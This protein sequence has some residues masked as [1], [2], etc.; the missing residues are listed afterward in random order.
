MREVLHGKRFEKNLKLVKKRGKDLNKIFKLIEILQKDE[1]I[2]ARYKN[3][4]LIGN[5]DGYWELHIEPDWL[6]IYS[7]TANELFLFTTGTHSDLF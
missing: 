6:L 4:K 5:Y 7:K 1:A 3:H 2:P